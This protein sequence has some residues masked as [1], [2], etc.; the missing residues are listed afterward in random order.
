M[1]ASKSY[2][3][4]RNTRIAMHG[5]TLLNYCIQ[6]VYHRASKAGG[7][8]WDCNAAIDLED[9]CRRWCVF[10][11]IDRWKDTPKTTAPDM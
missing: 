1:T 10:N 8:D 3:T 7:V 6:S 9:G 4:S 11:I 2:A 5:N